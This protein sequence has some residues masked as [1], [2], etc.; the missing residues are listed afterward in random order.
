MSAPSNYLKQCWNI[1]NSTPR[2]KLQWNINRNRCIFIHENAF[3]NV[4]CEMS[5]IVIGLNVLKFPVVTGWHRVGSHPYLQ[6]RR[7]M[8]QFQRHEKSLFTKADIAHLW[9]YI[10]YHFIIATHL[11]Y[12]NPGTVFTDTAEC[13]EST[14][15]RLNLFIINFSRFYQALLQ[16][17][18]R[19]GCQGNQ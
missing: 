18:A 1:V 7:F 4:F 14:V 3:K 19:P 15:K 6:A 2:N 12:M 13:P 17:I 16:T 10:I 8:V 11:S 5:A 9:L